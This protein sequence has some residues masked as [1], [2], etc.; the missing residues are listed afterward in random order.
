MLE[1]EYPTEEQM[2]EMWELF[3]SEEEAGGDFGG[4]AQAGTGNE[5]GEKL[6]DNPE[7]EWADPQNVDC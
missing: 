3:E 4:P 6:A 2:K 7:G 5:I 1:S